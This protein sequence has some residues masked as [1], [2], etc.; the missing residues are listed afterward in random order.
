MARVP[1]RYPA[2]TQVL[3]GLS[4]ILYHRTEPNNVAAILKED[5]FKLTFSGGSSADDVF[6]KDKSKWFYLSCART[7]LGSYGNLG[8]LVLDGKKLQERYTGGP[9][10][11]WGPEFRK[12]QKDKRE[13]EDRIWSHNQ[14]IPNAKQYIKEV[15]VL[16]YS[17]S[18]E[19]DFAAHGDGRYRQMLRTIAL[20]CKKSNIPVYFYRDAK[21]YEQL[22]TRHT[23]KPDFETNK[24][25]EF[26]KW[27]PS[28]PRPSYVDGIVELYWMQD[29]AEL[30]KEKYDSLLVR[31][32][33]NIQGIDRGAGLLSDIH[34]DKRAEK[35]ESLGRVLRDGKFKS[36]RE[37]MDFIIE[38]FKDA[39]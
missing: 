1:S 33:R 17:E 2:L 29:P 19:K 15:H 21:P 22:D 5:Q 7:P 16:L 12:V 27:S 23:V 25:N 38:K 11:Y 4:P 30:K 18:R 8:T 24:P 26:D 32:L 20:E 28:G 9:A 31:T 13:F 6:R 35:M 37:L 3:A 10:D 34:N 14:V 36:M 39:R